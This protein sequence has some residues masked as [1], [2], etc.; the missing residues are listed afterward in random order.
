MDQKYKKIHSCYVG[1]SLY[2]IIKYVD[3][4]FELSYK[5]K[6]QSHGF[7]VPFQVGTRGDD[8]ECA[9]SNSHNISDN[10]IL[11]VASDG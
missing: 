8:P 11:V 5:S 3:G 7:N 2:M 1:D 6:E 10:D 9:I 4:K